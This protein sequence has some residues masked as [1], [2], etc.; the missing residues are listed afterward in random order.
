MAKDTADPV[1]GYFLEIDA[2]HKELLGHIRHWDTLKGALSGSTLWIKG[3]M[4]AEADSIA[5]QAIPYIKLYYQK[6]GLLFAKGSL[7]PAKKLP[8]ALLWSPLNTMLPAALPPLNHNYFGISQKV[9][10]KL[11]QSAMEQEPVALLVTKD[12][13]AAYIESAPK[14]RLQRLLWAGIDDKVVLVGTPLL[15]VAGKAFWQQENM[16]LPAGYAL[17]LPVLAKAMKKML[18]PKGEHVIL[19]QQDGRYVLVP[20]D[21]LKPLSISSFRLTYSLT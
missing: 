2:A 9:D 19:W 14:V 17:E 12:E 7:L 4:P 11:V 16:L 3:I 6:E 15:P 8:S 20:T 18:D 10:V 21:A 13:A 5:I 1:D